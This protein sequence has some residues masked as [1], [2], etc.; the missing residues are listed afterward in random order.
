M[1][2]N[3]KKDGLSGVVDLLWLTKENASFT[4]EEGFLSLVVDG[5]AYDRVLLSR[6]FPFDEPETHISVTDC[7]Q[8]EIGMIR[9]L[10]ELSE[11]SQAACRLEL[12]RKYFTRV[13]LSIEKIKEHYG[14]THWDVTTKTG[15]VSFSVQDT[16]RSITKITVDHLLINDVD[17]NV[18]EILSVDAL[19]KKSYRQI[20]LYL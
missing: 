5:K 3:Q 8:Q 14:F 6:C 11:E 16:Y 12:S 17:G 7:E 2:E 10:Q 4:E 1:E 20:E 19:P 9:D 15:K 18:Y 13:I